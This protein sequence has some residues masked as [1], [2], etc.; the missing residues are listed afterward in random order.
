MMARPAI[1]VAIAAVTSMVTSVAHA[2][3]AWHAGLDLRVDQG[4]HPIRVGGGATFGSVDTLLVLDPM[5]VTD[6]QHDLDLLASFGERYGFLAGW[7]TTTI[8][9]A[10]GHQFQE[11]LIVGVS[12]PLPMI[13][14]GSIRARWA[15][16]F[17]TVIVKH[18]GDLPTEMISF[19][20]GRDFID[21]INFGMFVTFEYAGGH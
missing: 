19:A 8:G 15:L 9:I 11:K 14:G 18:G 10:G 13:A 7:R 17:A 2:D 21:L 12:A 6:G 5:V 20:S 1:V 3:T 16:E 4:A